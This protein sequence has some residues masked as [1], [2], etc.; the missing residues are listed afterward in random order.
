MTCNYPLCKQPALYTPVVEIPTIRTV[1][2]HK[3]VLTQAARDPFL[4]QSIGLST[5]IAIRQYEI[6]TEDYRLHSNDMVKTDKP[7]YLLGREVCQLHRD[8]YNLF[9]WFGANEWDHLVEAARHRG[10][11]LPLASNVIITFRPVGWR[12]GQTMEMER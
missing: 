7:T 6:A 4:M 9:D 10:F 2:M 5:P 1:G 12:P 11:D 3:P 8:T